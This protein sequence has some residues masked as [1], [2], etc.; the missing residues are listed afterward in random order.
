MLNAQT[1]GA[2]EQLAALIRERNQIDAQIAAVIA[3]PAISGHIGEFVASHVFG[4]ALERDVTTAGYD[5][6]FIAGPLAGKTV[7]IKAYGKRE[8]ALDINSDHVPDRYLVL[9]GPKAEPATS[10]G[11]HR[12]WVISEVFLFDARA[13]IDRLR[14]RQIN[15]GV[16][17]SVTSAEWET[18]RVF[19][20]SPSAPLKLPE[21]SI[22]LLNLFRA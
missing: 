4:I 10:R 15:I 18:A 6:C 1:T 12:P 19:P 21:E 3:R 22:R 14:S 5:G 2:I 13:L 17:T 20:P 7:N 16:A 8:N 9:A 11:G